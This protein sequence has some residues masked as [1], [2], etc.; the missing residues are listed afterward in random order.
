M[1][2]NNAE[3]SLRVKFNRFKHEL[4]SEGSTVIDRMFKKQP[5]KVRTETFDYFNEVEEQDYAFGI[6]ETTRNTIPAVI[7]QQR[8]RASQQLGKQLHLNVSRHVSQINALSNK[9][10]KKFYVQVMMKAEKRSVLKLVLQLLKANYRENILMDTEDATNRDNVT[11]NFPDSHIIMP[12]LNSVTVGGTTT[13]NSEF[14]ISTILAL[15]AKMANDVHRAPKDAGMV[16]Q[17]I[18]GEAQQVLIM[19]ASAKA[20]IL[21]R[22]FEA[23]GNADYYGKDLH[24]KGLNSVENLG[25]MMLVT[26]EDAYLPKATTSNINF[27]TP[28][29]NAGSLTAKHSDAPASGD[30]T[31]NGCYEILH[32]IPKFLQ[33]FNPAQYDENHDYIDFTKNFNEKLWTLWA[34]AGIR[35]FDV[36]NRLYVTPQGTNLTLA[37]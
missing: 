21:G 1:G 31:E 22:N 9:E 20:D 17:D 6:S 8:R 34:C 27:G 29:E 33:L 23:F 14:D 25:N 12:K 3:A 24:F 15:E 28:A 18:N 10:L 35:E 32:I 37:S 26:I 30:I 36:F 2:F 7:P 19:S 13:Y 4:Q 16:M 11:V 5:T